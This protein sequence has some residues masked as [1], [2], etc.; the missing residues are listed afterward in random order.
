[1]D[2]VSEDWHR[3]DEFVIEKLNSFAGAF[4]L[5]YDAAQ[6]AADA[7]CSRWEFA[8]SFAE[9]QEIGIRTNDV[10]WLMC[11]HWLLHG[12]DLSSPGDEH[13]MV[14]E[15]GGVVFDG[16]SCFT[17]SDEGQ[18]LVAR[19]LRSFTD[20]LSHLSLAE[21]E[22]R[23]R[24]GPCWDAARHELR[25]GTQLIK[26]FRWPALNQ[27]TILTAFEED[28]WPAKIDD[29]LSQ[30]PDLDPKRRLADA[31]KCL[32]RNQESRLLRFRGDG[33]GEGVLWD[34]LD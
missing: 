29:P 13:R 19:Q 7:A 24:S 15:L 10:R 4:T 34:R 25:L 14:R 8:I 9:L 11:R 26:R 6:Y 33:T 20:T 22:P 1:M 17:L 18:Q 3:E 28:G 32:N 27:E 2:V 31:I 5:L 23:A 30:K 21:E 12:Q 16:R